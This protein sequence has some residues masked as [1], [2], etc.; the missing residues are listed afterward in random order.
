MSWLKTIDGKYWQVNTLLLNNNDAV[1]IRIH[2]LVYLC[3]KR[4]I[5]NNL[6]VLFGTYV[7][8]H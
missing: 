7:N 2:L 6:C 4:L 3:M 1:I 5:S 8:V